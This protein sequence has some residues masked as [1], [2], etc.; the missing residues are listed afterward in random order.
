MSIVFF[1]WM[2]DHRA[3]RGVPFGTIPEALGDI[4]YRAIDFG[5]NAIRGSVN[6]MR[7]I[8]DADHFWE[9]L[10]FHGELLP[11]YTHMGCLGSIE[12]EGKRVWYMAG[13]FIRKD[14]L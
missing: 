7:G 8:L 3:L 5:Y 6:I 14:L 11:G 12:I 4:I 9:W 1:E 10:Q 2:W 13:F